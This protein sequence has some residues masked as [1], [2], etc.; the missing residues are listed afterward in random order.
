MQSP[1]HG[2]I[3][4]EAG[5]TMAAAIRIVCASALPYIDADI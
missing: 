5:I 2:R 4:A 3:R 1:R